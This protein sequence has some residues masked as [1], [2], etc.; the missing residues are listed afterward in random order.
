MNERI[1]ISHWHYL[2]HYLL[3]WIFF[4]P[5]LWA[6]Y[7][8]NALVLV[9]TDS[10]IE[11][12]RGWL[13]KNKTFIAYGNIRSINVQQTF[14][15]RIWFKIGR[16]SIAS[17]GTGGYEISINGIPDP[18]EL[19]KRILAYIDSKK[20]PPTHQP[21]LS[22]QQPSSNPNL[23]ACPDCDAWISRRA[24]VCP[25]CGCPF[26]QRDEPYGL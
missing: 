13:S 23:M 6:L 9:I 17:A 24:P 22:Q 18:H 5:P 4:V 3:W 11:L 2:W 25:K 10:E 19:K 26:D 8:R 16:L 15:Q 20:E 12:E 14:L 21:P 7:E 1:L